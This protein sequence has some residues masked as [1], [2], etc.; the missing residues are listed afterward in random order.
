MTRK[1]IANSFKK[2][3][4]VFNP[5][6]SK[7]LAFEGNGKVERCVGGYSDYLNQKKNPKKLVSEKNNSKKQALTDKEKEMIYKLYEKDFEI[8]KYSK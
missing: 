4:I 5:N 8:L 2:S 1:K 6:I 3:S 7:I